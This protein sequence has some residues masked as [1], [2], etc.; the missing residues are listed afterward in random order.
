MASPKVQPNREDFRREDG[1]IDESAWLDAMWEWQNQVTSGEIYDPRDTQVT[2]DPIKNATDPTAAKPEEPSQPKQGAPDRKPYWW[3]SPDDDRTND[4][5]ADWKNAV[6]EDSETK[7]FSSDAQAGMA[8]A[9]AAGDEAGYNG[10]KDA[11]RERLARGAGHTPENPP[12]NPGQASG[13]KNVTGVTDEQVAG[14]TVKDVLQLLGNPEG[15][16]DELSGYDPDEQQNWID[17]VM[18]GDVGRGQK[19]VEEARRRQ[20]R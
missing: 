17:A 6:F 11:E 15:Y 2:P 9:R 20:G 12:K 10:I 5:G 3:E 19:V 16:F 8:A 13:Q 1:T 7:Q 14:K 4:G 18:R